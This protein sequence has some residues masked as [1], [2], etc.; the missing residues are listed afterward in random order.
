MTSRVNNSGF[1]CRECGVSLLVDRHFLS[2][3]S[4]ALPCISTNLK[5]SE[6][7]R[8]IQS[9]ILRSDENP[10][11]FEYSKSSHFPCL[12]VFSIA[13]IALFHVSAQKKSPPDRLK[14]SAGV[15]KLE[16]RDIYYSSSNG[17]AQSKVNCF[18]WCT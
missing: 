1:R 16:M 7:S 2:V 9:R 13:I 14:I 11:V 18:I 6:I 4:K 5:I 17:D 8:Q 10:Y 12:T 3:T 15:V